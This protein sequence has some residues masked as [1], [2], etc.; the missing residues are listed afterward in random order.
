MPKSQNRN[1]SDLKSHKVVRVNLL[2]MR[3]GSAQRKK[4]LQ[5]TLLLENRFRAFLSEIGK[6]MVLE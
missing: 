4:K 5:H 2:K 6:H 3:V 1:R